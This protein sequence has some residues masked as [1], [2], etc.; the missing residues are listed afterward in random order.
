VLTIAR[1]KQVLHYNPKTGEFRWRI[2]L[3]ARTPVGSVAGS[4]HGVAK[5]YT[6][7]GIDGQRYQA[8]R[9]A[10]LYVTGRWPV[11]EI[12]H[13][14]GYSNRFSNL[15][16][17]THEQNGRNR[18]RNT[19]NT[20]GFK[21]VLWYPRHRKWNA[22]IGVGGKRVNLGYFDSKRAAA[23]ARRRAAREHHGDY[24]R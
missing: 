6:Q 7:I 4:K 1:L 15:R 22:F 13:K 2:R 17:A 3:G 19:N 11:D 10:W 5:N 16:E 14:R 12:D 9:L 18:K 23:Q 21:G 8:H 24:A 20:S